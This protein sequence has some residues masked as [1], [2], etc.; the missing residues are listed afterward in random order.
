[1]VMRMTRMVAM[2]IQAGVALVDGR[3]SEGRR[4]RGTKG[5]S[6]PERGGEETAE[7]SRG[8]R[9]VNLLHVQG[10]PVIT[11][12]KGPLP[13]DSVPSRGAKPRSV[14]VSEAA[15]MADFGETAAPPRLA[16]A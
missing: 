4:N 15:E 5:G 12:G 13:I 2:S 14:P 11:P 1:M 6:R 3:S 8:G 16:F 10:S 9:Q 7:P